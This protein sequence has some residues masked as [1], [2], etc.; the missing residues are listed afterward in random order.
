MNAVIRNL[1]RHYANGLSLPD[2]M[3]VGEKARLFV[4]GQESRLARLT[5][6]C[7]DKEFELDA[8]FEHAD[9]PLS[10]NLLPDAS[11]LICVEPTYSKAD[12]CYVLDAYGKLRYRLTVPCELTPYEIPSTAKRWF[13]GSSA[14][15]DGQFGITAWIE[16]AGDFY[17]EL[18]YLAGRF[19][20]GKEI[21][22]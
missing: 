10:V 18:D 1:T 17:F 16:C 2:S 22:F 6:D 8:H 21:R 12:N 11:G 4:S 5:W 9:I 13:R 3:S 20:W 7:I 19:L 15:H 14:H